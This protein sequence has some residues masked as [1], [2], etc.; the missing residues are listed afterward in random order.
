MWLARNPG[1]QRP[2]LPPGGQ[3]GVAVSEQHGELSARAARGG[4]GG[5]RHDH[6]QPA[7]H[8]PRLPAEQP[9]LS[10]DPDP[11]QQLRRQPQPGTKTVAL[12]LSKEKWGDF[13]H[14]VK[15]EETASSFSKLVAFRFVLTLKGHGKVRYRLVVSFGPV[16][17]RFAVF[18]YSALTLFPKT[19]SVSHVASSFLLCV[20]MCSLDVGTF[21][22]E[23]ELELAAGVLQAAS[24]IVGAS[25]EAPTQVGSAATRFSKSYEDFVDSGLEFAGTNRTKSVYFAPSKP[26]RNSAILCTACFRVQFEKLFPL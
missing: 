3:G 17:T 24:D 21:L 22:C 5:A 13:E 11:T 18:C 10:G 8:E 14:R 12:S 4:H 6:H 16:H 19:P 2:C 7:P 9:E 23:H 15:Q 1:H 25:R 20:A 26:T